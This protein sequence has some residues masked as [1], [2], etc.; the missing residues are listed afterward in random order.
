M[1]PW[2]TVVL[3]FGEALPLVNLPKAEKKSDDN[4]LR[5]ADSFFGDSF[6][7]DVMGSPEDGANL[8]M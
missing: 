5:L 4:P 7:G 3:A 2:P 1:P 8:I 6:Y